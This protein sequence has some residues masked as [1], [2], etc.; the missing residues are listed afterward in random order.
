MEKEGTG[1]TSN[2]LCRGDSPRDRDI[3]QPGGEAAS[4]LDGGSVAVRI[5]TLEEGFL[6][7]FKAQNLKFRPIKSAL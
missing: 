7:H 4:H 1:S 3:L 5:E 6:N 2:H